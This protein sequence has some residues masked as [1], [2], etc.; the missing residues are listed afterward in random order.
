MAEKYYQSIGRRKTSVAQVR[1][2]PGGKGVIMVNGKDYKEYFPLP[3]LRDAIERPLRET[4][5]LESVDI[6][7]RTVGG[8]H[9]GQ[10]D[11]VMMGI[12]RALVK[13]DESLRMVM[14]AHGLLT[15]DARKKERKRR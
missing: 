8:G 5:K 9:T 13:Y 4:G 12:A 3:M 7:V 10:A 14:R 2:T 6:S 11:A 1:L 15:R